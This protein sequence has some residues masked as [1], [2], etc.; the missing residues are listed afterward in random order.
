[1]PRRRASEISTIEA[2]LLRSRLYLTCGPYD[3]TAIRTEKLLPVPPTIVELGQRGL[4][5]PAYLQ[6]LL[7]LVLSNVWA[8]GAG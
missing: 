4:R 2:R 8:V 3:R 7:F 6:K 1:M 5:Y